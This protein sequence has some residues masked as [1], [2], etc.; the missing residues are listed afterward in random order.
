MAITEPLRSSPETRTTTAGG[1][2]AAALGITPD[3]ATA[4]APGTPGRQRSGVGESSAVLAFDRAAATELL[5]QPLDT[6]STPCVVE[7]L[8]SLSRRRGTPSMH[9][10][11][12]TRGLL[13]ELRKR[14]PALFEDLDPAAPGYLRDLV[15]RAGARTPKR[16]TPARDDRELCEED[17]RARPIE[18]DGTG[19]SGTTCS[20][21]VARRVPLLPGRKQYG[22]ITGTEPCGDLARWSAR[23]GAWNGGLPEVRLFCSRHAAAWLRTTASTRP[24]T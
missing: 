6:A 7:A 3:T 5:R 20:T 12:A 17:P 24:S 15:K 22:L 19:Y 9:R 1:S 16:G 23:T 18:L 21:P 14:E 10:I 2:L 11:G 4:P 8:A 13:T